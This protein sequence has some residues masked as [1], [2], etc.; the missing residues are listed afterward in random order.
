[1]AQLWL[2]AES[3]GGSQPQDSR[4]HLRSSGLSLHAETV[5]RKLES[6]SGGPCRKATLQEGPSGGLP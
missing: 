4:A 5:P 1:M 2:D 3:C 6:V